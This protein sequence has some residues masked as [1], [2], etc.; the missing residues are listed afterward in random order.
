MSAGSHEPIDCSHSASICLIFGYPR[1]PCLRV[2][3]DYEI[4][5]HHLGQTHPPMIVLRHT[6]VPWLDC[7][8]DTFV[9]TDEIRGDETEP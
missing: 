1:E 2:L 8:H 7:V 5:Y 9:E 4:C 3:Y 6:G